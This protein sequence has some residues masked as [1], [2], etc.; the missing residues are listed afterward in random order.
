MQGVWGG[1]VRLALEARTLLDRVVQLGV[2][3]THLVVVREELEALGEA[4]RPIARV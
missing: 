2:R 3:V 1:R 4:L